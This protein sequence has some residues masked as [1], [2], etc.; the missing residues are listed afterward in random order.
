MVTL[1]PFGNDALQTV[2]Q[3][4]PAGVVVMVPCPV[5]PT[6]R[7]NI[8]GAG[9][10]VGAGVG[11]GVGRGVGV[12]VGAGMGVVP[13]LLTVTVLTT[14]ATAPFDAVALA[15]N[16]CVPL[17]NAVVMRNPAGLSPLN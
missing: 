15:V 5:F 2:P 6:E 11:R 16:T 14:V 1:A 13:K 8:P 12:G 7:M 10:G 3:L 17:D 9:V 4:I